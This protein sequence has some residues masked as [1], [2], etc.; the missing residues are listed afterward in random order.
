MSAVP[1]TRVTCLALVTLLAGCRGEPQGDRHQ[2]IAGTVESFSGETGELSIHNPGPRN[3]PEAEERVTCVITNRS[4]VYVNDKFARP[5]SIGV[6][7]QIEVLGRREADP[8]SERIVVTLAYVT[9]PSKRSPAP[10]GPTSA[11]L[12]SQEK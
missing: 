1:L 9:R 7:D 4:E 5:E 8:R 3:Q 2:L 10:G 12:F 6:G 11:P